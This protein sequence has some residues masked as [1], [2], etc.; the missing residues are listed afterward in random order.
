[1]TD[2]FWEEFINERVVIGEYFTVANFTV[3]KE[4]TPVRKK[5]ENLEVSLPSI[6]YTKMDYEPIH[7]FDWSIGAFKWGFR[8]IAEF[9][10]ATYSIDLLKYKGREGNNN[11]YIDP[12]SILNNIIQKLYHA[13]VTLDPDN[14]VMQINE[15]MDVVKYLPLI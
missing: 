8:I 14:T 1:M 4:Y 6:V 13:F 7:F 11:L 3:R 5:Y 10:L 15:R 2:V 9:T 12:T